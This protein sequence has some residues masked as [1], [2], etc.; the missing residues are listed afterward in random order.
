[1]LAD[2]D[3]Q[4]GSNGTLR[5]ASNG[6]GSRPVEGG[7][8]TTS[9][10]ARKAAPSEAMNG[11]S[12]NGKE[13][14]KALPHAYRGHSR[15]EV[16]RILIQALSDMGYSEAA[17]SVS[18]DSGY[19]LES[20]TVAAFRAAVLDGAWSR[21]E[22]LLAGALVI[23]ESQQ[24]GNGLVLAPGAD[25]NIMRI[26][27][28]Q[29]KFLELLERRESSRALV[30]LRSELTPLCA[31]QHQ[32]LH[33]LSSLLMCQSPEDLKFKANWD[34]ALG[35]SRRILL[36]ELS[37][38]ISPSVMLPESRLAVLLE[39][40]KESQIGNCLFHTSSRP[41]SLYSDHLCDKSQ[42]PTEVIYEL[43]KQPGELWQV[44]FS[45]DGTKLASCGSDKSVYIWAVPSFEVLHRLDA[46]QEKGVGD[47]AWSPDDS[48]LVTC[49]MDHDAK[50]WNIE[51]GACIK[52][53]DRFV[54]PVSSCVWAA[55]S[56][57]FILGTFDVTKSLSQW[58][59]RGERVFNWPKKHRTQ[60]LA[61]SPDGRWLV[62][63]DEQSHLYIY[64]LATRE[65]EYEMELKSRATSISVSHDSRF[66]LVNQVD[67]IAQLIDIAS[68]ESIQ[69]YTGGMG[70]EYTIRSS[71]GGANE[72]FVISGS[73]DGNLCIWHKST[74]IPVERLSAHQPRCNAV[75]WNP[76]DPCM[77]ASCGD[78]GKI[79]IWSNKE[80]LRSITRSIQANGDSRSSN[81]WRS[82][83]EE[84][85]EV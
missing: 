10:G 1:M 42:F 52:V 63:M 40:V 35:Q 24:S 18:R 19:D 17:Q 77:F 84:A 46:A 4:E 66:L 65:L 71:F 81:G 15:E 36:S 70:G 68:R 30:V 80:R 41:P 85:G 69:K 28:R 6:S 72:S 58:D 55:D 25:R 74:G 51:T 38:C 82:A 56:R 2:S 64:N 16:T 23:G 78:D 67:G 37:R 20:P 14:S 61:A 57:S 39:Q 9:N 8:A 48:M 34:G 11:S 49:G 22:E 21:A 32:K 75:S 50:I 5:A 73:E 33:F 26:W 53:L 44:V 45:H 3:G 47:V 27:L 79:K 12:Q 43:D 54:E 7:A 83:A 76:N 62:A 29:Q 60:D 59:L 13:P 31:E